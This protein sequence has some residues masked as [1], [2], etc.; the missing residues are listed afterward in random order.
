M[1]AA[2]VTPAG[3]RVPGLLQKSVADQTVRVWKNSFLALFSAGEVLADPCAR[4][5]P[6]QEAPSVRTACEF[7]SDEG[8]PAF[9]RLHPKP[10]RHR[11][12]PRPAS[13]PAV[14]LL[15]HPEQWSLR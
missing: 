6:L 3:T 10:A 15:S 8:F 2:P 4:S 11:T 5:T 14:R 1:P 7:P 12:A 13:C 9:L